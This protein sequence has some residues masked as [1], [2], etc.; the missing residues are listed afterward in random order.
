ML[1]N[2]FTGPGSRLPKPQALECECVDCDQ[3]A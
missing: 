3:Q 1:H 2:G